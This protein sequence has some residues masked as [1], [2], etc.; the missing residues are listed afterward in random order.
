MLTK[1]TSE[2]ELKEYLMEFFKMQHNW[3]FRKKKYR[4][5]SKARD[6]FLL[7][8]DNIELM[9]M[10]DSDKEFSKFLSEL[11]DNCEDLNI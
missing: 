8:L 1:L 10:N 9:I 6:P 5:D 2:D 3:S 7:C 11:Y 4:S